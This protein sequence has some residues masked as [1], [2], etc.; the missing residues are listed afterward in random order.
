MREFSEHSILLNAD[1][2]AE[3]LGISKRTVWRLRSAG[4]MPPPVQIG[5]SIR[6]QRSEIE[7]WVATGCPKQISH[8]KSN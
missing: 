8:T 1:D 5:S 2:L 6:W 3:L 4:A 7:S